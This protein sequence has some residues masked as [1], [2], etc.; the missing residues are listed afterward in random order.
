MAKVLLYT[1]A[2]FL[3]MKRSSTILTKTTKRRRMPRAKVYRPIKYDRQPYKI[4]YAYPMTSS[5]AG[6]IDDVLSTSDPAGA[7]DSAGTYEDWT[8][9]A[10]IWD[11]YKVTGLRVQYTP[12]LTNG[13]T[14]A[15]Q[16]MYII[17]DHD[18]VSAAAS[19][20]AQIQYDKVKFVNVNEKWDL[21]F[22]VG[23]TTQTGNPLTFLNVGTAGSATNRISSVK[24][25]CDNLAASQAY[26]VILLT[27]YITFGGRR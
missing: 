4:R 11:S 10:A 20:G 15:I 22:K 24:L 18:D 23:P 12:T 13:S 25:F 9:L 3:I 26:G 2:H 6:L 8:S 17:Q 27:M 19:Y 21:F 16:P 5:A 7:V 1:S 14:V